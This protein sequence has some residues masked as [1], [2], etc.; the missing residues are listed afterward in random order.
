M[1]FYVNRLKKNICKLVW[2]LAMQNIRFIYER[3]G[4]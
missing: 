4:N 2:V 1:T 3:L